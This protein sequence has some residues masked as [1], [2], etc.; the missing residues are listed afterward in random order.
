MA[1]LAGA[2]RTVAKGSLPWYS[3]LAGSTVYAASF[4]RAVKDADLKALDRYFAVIRKRSRMP[5]M[6]YAVNGIGFYL[7]MTAGKP[8][9][10]F[11]TA[12]YIKPGATQ[13]TYEPGPVRRT[14]HAVLPLYRKLAC[15]P[16]FARHTAGLI[17]KGR[18]AAFRRLIRAYVRS[19]YLSEVKR[20][21]WGFDLLFRYPD[22]PYVY[23]NT[24]YRQHV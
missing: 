3:R 2:L 9:G 6:S 22:T 4:C 11:A 14:A 10:E 19:P 15:S 23:R 20:E 5:N 1:M 8:P 12:I 17:R 18:T 16:M 24:I 7:E 21:A 13:F